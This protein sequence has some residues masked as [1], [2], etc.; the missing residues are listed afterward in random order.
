MLVAYSALAL[1]GELELADLAYFAALVFALI[2]GWWHHKGGDRAPTEKAAFQ[3][4]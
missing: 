1:L 4:T 3:Y 2:S